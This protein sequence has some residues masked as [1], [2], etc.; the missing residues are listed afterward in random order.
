MSYY[1]FLKHNDEELARIAEEI[2]DLGSGGIGENWVD[3]RLFPPH[4]EK[5]DELVGQ[6]RER[7]KELQNTI[8]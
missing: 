8:Y 2:D 5:A 3:W 7:E 6:F 1:F 4:Y